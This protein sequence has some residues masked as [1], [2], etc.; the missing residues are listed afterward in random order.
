MRRF[1]VLSTTA[2]LVL[3][4]CSS[5]GSKKPATAS[6]TTSTTSATAVTGQAF[7]PEPS[8]VQGTCGVGMV[9]D[10]AFK[11]KDASLLKVGF[12][13][14]SPGRPGRNAVFPSLA[15]TLSTTDTAL[16]GPQA[17]LADLFQIVSISQQA[18]GSTQAWA[19]WTNP[20]ARFGVD[21]DSVLEAYVL[22]GDAPAT[23][24]ADHTGL[25]LVS[26]VIHT[27]FHVGGPGCTTTSSSSSSV[28]GASTTTRPT[29]ATTRLTTTTKATTTTTTTKVSTTV[30]GSTTPVT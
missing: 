4:A 29:T 22:R 25:D 1:L 18:D 30:P 15:V 27:A 11:S 16:G 24:P 13:A 26:N 2:A 8:S 17:N 28:P 23:L 5:G 19:T 3:A 6:T 12:R 7:S 21:V 20:A 14:I 9:V 10:L